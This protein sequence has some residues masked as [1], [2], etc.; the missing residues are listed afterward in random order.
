MSGKAHPVSFHVIRGALEYVGL[1]VE[2]IRVT[3]PC[4]PWGSL[5]E[6]RV[7]LKNDHPFDEYAS[8]P[9]D[10]FDQAQAAFAN[11][12]EIHDVE[13][14]GGKWHLIICCDG[15]PLNGRLKTARYAQIEAK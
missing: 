6:L 12:V 8:R 4:P 2:R 1:Q 7:T 5:E 14:V 10:I 11:D 13:F 3:K 15:S 9:R